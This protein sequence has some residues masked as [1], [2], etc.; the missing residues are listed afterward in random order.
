MSIADGGD[1]TR[2]GETAMPETTNHDDLEIG[3]DLTITKTTRWAA[4]AELGS[5]AD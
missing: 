4:G 2:T 5:W 3:D 1:Q